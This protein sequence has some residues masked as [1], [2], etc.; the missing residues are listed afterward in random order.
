MS[1]K[2]TDSS[3]I[4]L[5]EGKNDEHIMYALFE[6][7]S[8]PNTF[9]VIDCEGID[10]L[11][12]GIGVRLKG[13]NLK[14]LGIIVDAD[15]D[16]QSQWQ[17]LKDILKESGYTIP[18]QIP[19]EGLIVE[20]NDKKIGIWVM[21]NNNSNGM[22]EDFIRFL[23]PDNDPLISLAENTLAYIEGKSLNHY[24][25]DLHKSKALIHTWLAWQEAPGTPLGLAIT[26]RYL[27]TENKEICER[28]I[29]WINNLFIT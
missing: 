8:I 3:A 29:H 23:V 14:R 6:R 9:K 13:G 5:V 2:K 26:K 7:Y 4:L 27:T 20:Q 15:N 25:K 1:N 24:N 18:I 17:S 22:I 21:P 28:F 16:I 19:Q 11:I 12:E 10:K